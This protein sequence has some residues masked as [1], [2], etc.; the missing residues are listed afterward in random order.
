MKEILKPLNF[1]SE[2]RIFLK[3][4]NL[5]IFMGSN[6]P[7][8]ERFQATISRAQA[9]VCIGLDPDPARIP[10][11]LGSGVAAA[12][13]F[14]TSIIEAT[15]DLT[16]AFKPN[17]AYFEAYGHEGWALLERL[18]DVAGP[19][20]L[21]IV[22]AKR[23]DIEHTNEAYARALFDILKA[24]AV[25]VQPYAGGAALEPFS[26]DPARGVFVLCAT[27]NAGAES[28]QEFGQP[29]H[30]LYLEIA[31]QAT[32]WSK[33]NNVGLVMGT[34][35]PSALENVLRV[36]PNLPLLLPGG[37]TQGGGTTRVRQLLRQYQAFG[38]LF[39]FSRSVLYKSSGPDFAE[40][41]RAEV[42]LLRGTLQ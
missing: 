18:P 33:H 17:T 16:A 12:E 38:G 26:R 7:F 23:G 31:K 11:H 40:A 29:D 9:P 19:E 10:V 24:D 1:L 34:T 28:V 39:N 5:L 37:G 22:D 30:P 41:A 15:R 4:R 32:S 20:V 14:L 25:T 36:A 3:F 8:R 6:A 13:R 42:L 21:W 2:I 27:S 35:K